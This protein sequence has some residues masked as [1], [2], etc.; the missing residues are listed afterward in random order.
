[1]IE[2]MVNMAWSEMPV[3]PVREYTTYVVKKV[4]QRTPPKTD[5]S[6]QN[7]TTVWLIRKLNMEWVYNSIFRKQFGLDK[8]AMKYSASKTV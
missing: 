1:M 2:A 3:M 7:A 4:I 5:W 8:L 6:G